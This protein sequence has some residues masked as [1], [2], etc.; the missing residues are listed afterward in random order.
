MLD[1]L[2]VQDQLKNFSQEQLLKEMK[3][4]SGSVPQFLVLSELN[5][6]RTM[7]Q[8]MAK[9]QSADQPTVKEEVVASSGMPMQETSMLAQQMSPQTSMTENTGIASMMPRELPSEEE[10]MKMSYGGVLNSRAM[11]MEQPLMR[12]GQPMARPL[13]FN[14]R[15]QRD[16][17]G[18]KNLGSN[19]VNKIG[20]K[21]QGEVDEFIGEV[22]DMADERFDLD[23]TPEPQFDSGG[24]GFPPFVKPSIAQRL[25]SSSTMYRKEGGPI[26]AQNG[27]FADI[28]RAI[29][30]IDNTTGLS[31]PLTLPP[32]DTNLFASSMQPSGVTS[33]AGVYNFIKTN[34][35]NMSDAEARRQAESIVKTQ[36]QD[37]IPRLDVTVN[38]GLPAPD[39]KLFAGSLGTDPTYDQFKI[40]PQQYAPPSSEGVSGGVDF[41]AT[42]PNISPVE[43]GLGSLT[44]D[45]DGMV[46]PELDSI[47][48]GSGISGTDLPPSETL[49][50]STSTGSKSRQKSR[51]SQGQTL[52][53][54]IRRNFPVT[55]ENI[56]FGEEDASG[57]TR[58]QYE[59]IFKDG[60]GDPSR[61]FMSGTDLERYKEIFKDGRTSPFEAEEQKNKQIMDNFT[62]GEEMN[63]L[64]DDMIK[65]EEKKKDEQKKKDEDSDSGGLG[66]LGGASGA[67][68][69]LSAQ[70]AELKEKREK[71][72][73]S[74][75]WF[76]LAKLGLGM[77]A[78][79]SPT[80]FGALG[81]GGLKA[82]E[83][84]KAGKKAYDDDILGYLKV[85]AS[86]EKTKGDQAVKSAYYK[87]VLENAKK[88]GLTGMT[89][90]ER[91]TA[92]LNID[93]ELND[94]Y[95]L[96]DYDQESPK[97][98]TAIFNLEAQKRRLQLNLPL[99]PTVIDK[100]LTSTVAT[101]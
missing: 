70:I 11:V 43:S 14:M 86:I 28:G 41:D 79:A 84:F 77:L 75:K 30:S 9:R 60:R 55:A 73:D 36:Q 51:N 93:K 31:N 45:I 53:Q 88:K 95:K 7:S 25:V 35:P 18:F 21:S 91:A 94:L 72:R 49:P 76:S 67:L 13:P 42:A 15:Q 39:Q 100:D 1:V 78:S 47:N 97:V 19:I 33:F 69:E 65:D 17:L 12:S 58:R 57:T 99:A 44:T 101:S 32:P 50:V 4:P 52:S 34:F 89:Q 66:G 83:D 20:E 63:K 5:R 98:K 22:R 80:V 81:E 62:G 59:D 54:F 2:E 26:K 74:E 68:S 61:P 23:I 71:G 48:V 87:G 29:G 64:V 24:K 96:G 40:K 37:E 38:K 85:Q 46:S 92:I 10:P 56:G 6:R 90:K 8:D 3:M 27:M 16:N 82:L